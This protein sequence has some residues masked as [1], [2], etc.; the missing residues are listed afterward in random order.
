[1]IDRKNFEEVHKLVR[2]MSDG[3]SKNRAVSN[4]QTFVFSATL[5]MV[6]Q[7][8]DRLKATHK[9]VSAPADI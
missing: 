3:A 6:H 5:T 2:L 4:R 8:P 9:S 7:L 1:M